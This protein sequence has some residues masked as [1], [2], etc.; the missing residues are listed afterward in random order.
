MAHY[1]CE[2]LAVT[3]GRKSGVYVV[4]AETPSEYR[5]TGCKTVKRECEG[6]GGEGGEEVEGE[7]VPQERTRRRM[8]MRRGSRGCHNREMILDK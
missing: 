6:R 7:E 2:I 3:R 5:R 1:R 8:E 4:R